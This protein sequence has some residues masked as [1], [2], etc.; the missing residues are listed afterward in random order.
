ML[1]SYLPA[2]VVIGSRV[3]Q[4]STA[5]CAERGANS[6][7]GPGFPVGPSSFCEC[8][9]DAQLDHARRFFSGIHGDGSDDRVIPLFFR[10]DDVLA[11]Q[12]QAAFDS[13][14]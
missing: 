4:Q 9:V 10:R 12:E 13:W 11:G 7:D 1:R 3:R 2:P 6:R 8:R 14:G 5:D